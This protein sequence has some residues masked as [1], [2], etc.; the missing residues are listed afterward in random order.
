MRWRRPVAVNVTPAN[1]KVE[2]RCALIGIG[3]GG[4]AAE[5]GEVAHAVVGGVGWG[6]AVR[7]E[8]VLDGDRRSTR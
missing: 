8:P 7:I 5:L 2:R 6:A 3:L 4:V 1:G